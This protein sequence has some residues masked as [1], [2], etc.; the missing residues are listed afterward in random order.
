MYKND[1]PVEK[2]NSLLRYPQQESCESVWMKITARI[3]ESEKPDRSFL[4]DGIEKV[5]GEGNWRD[6]LERR[7]G[8]TKWK[9]EKERLNGKLKW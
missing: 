4:N 9:D 3:S 5:N 6:E 1:V 2:L 7:T 8:E